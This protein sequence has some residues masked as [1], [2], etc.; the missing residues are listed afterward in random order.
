MEV[1]RFTNSEEVFHL[2][3]QAFNETKKRILELIPRSDVQH[4]GSTAIPGS[5]TKGD[6]DIQVRVSPEDFQDTAEALSAIYEINDGSTQTKS[7]QSFKDDC[8]TPP[9]GIQLTVIDSDL[10]IFWRL[11]DVLM[12]NEHLRTEY[13]QLKS[14]CHGKRMEEYRQEKSLFFQKVMDSEEFRSL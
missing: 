8:A 12:K 5:M 7:F 3:E 6:L 4:V 2:A 14:S 13:D 1:L 11:R 10:D 9:L